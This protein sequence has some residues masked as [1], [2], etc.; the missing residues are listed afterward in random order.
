MTAVEETE[1]GVSLSELVTD[2][3]T[4]RRC[5]PV[6]PHTTHTSTTNTLWG[7]RWGTP[8]QHTTV[9]LSALDVAL[10]GSDFS[11]VGHV[12]GLAVLLYNMDSL[13]H[14]SFLPLPLHSPSSLF[15]WDRRHSRTPWDPSLHFDISNPLVW[16]SIAI[17]P[18]CRG[19][20]CRPQ[21]SHS[22]Y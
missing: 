12:W 21:H 11:G 14:S 22:K 5:C 16:H 1:R 17:L 3:V 15:T 9:S 19:T 8:L 6:S 4:T 20:F 10:D 7:V 18:I 2:P 13:T